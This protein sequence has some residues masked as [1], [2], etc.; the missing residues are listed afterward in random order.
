MTSHL[1]SICGEEAAGDAT[2]TIVTKDGRPLQGAERKS[3]LSKT[4]GLTTTGVK[5]LAPAH[6]YDTITMCAYCIDELLHT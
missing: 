4:R 6:G 5:Q 1:C 3:F 2:Y